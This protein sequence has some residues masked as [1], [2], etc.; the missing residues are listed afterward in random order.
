MISTERNR[1][2]YEDDVRVNFQ[3][4]DLFSMILWTMS[5][6]VRLF[7][8]S[9]VLNIPLFLG[10]WG[11]STNSYIKLIKGPCQHLRMMRSTL[12]PIRALTQIQN[13]PVTHTCE[14]VIYCVLHRHKW[15]KCTSTFWWHL[16]L[17]S[18]K[19]ECTYCKSHWTRASAAL[20]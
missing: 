8:L 10:S 5:S 3:V 13:W 16:A 4:P 20:M 11:Q 6:V 9:M 19:Y 7:P 12:E 15:K 17:V 1:N 2:A 14:Y 18:S